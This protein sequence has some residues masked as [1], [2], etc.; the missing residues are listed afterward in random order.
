MIIKRIMACLW[1]GIRIGASKSPFCIYE[2]KDLMIKKHTPH[3]FQWSKLAQGW[4]GEGLVGP[5]RG[6]QRGL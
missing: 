5:I 2:T 6:S 3:Y 1:C 4:Y